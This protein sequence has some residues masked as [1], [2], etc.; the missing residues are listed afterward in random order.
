MNC[1]RFRPLLSRFAE[2]E[3]DPAEALGLAGHLASCT[4]CKILLARERRLHAALD[5]LHDPVAVDEEF[6]RLVMAALP[7]GPPPAAASRPKRPA[8]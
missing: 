8:I 4:A 2:G 7:A 6:S 1:E 3:A 5:G